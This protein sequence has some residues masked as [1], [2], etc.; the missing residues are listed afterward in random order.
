MH[1]LTSKTQLRCT[2][3]P[4][5]GGGPSSIL[6]WEL[7]MLYEVS[8]NGIRALMGTMHNLKSVTGSD[9]DVV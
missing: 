7:L 2:V 6:L 4:D 1:V 3:V 5:E 9:G 8:E